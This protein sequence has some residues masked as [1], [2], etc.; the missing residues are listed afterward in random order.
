[1]WCRYEKFDHI[2]PGLVTN[3]LHFYA[4]G[5]G[6]ALLIDFHLVV[7]KGRIRQTE[8]EWEANLLTKAVKIAVAY[9]DI[10]V[11]IGVIDIGFDLPFGV[12]FIIAPH[13]HRG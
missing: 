12:F 9:L 6:I 13:I 7:S 2:P 1:M 5:V 10:F 4:N 8:A 3:I 11:I